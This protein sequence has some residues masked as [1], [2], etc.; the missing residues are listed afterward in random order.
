M[1]AT[2][3]LD[4]FRVSKTNSVMTNR[5]S[6]RMQSLC[7]D[8]RSGD[9][10]ITEVKDPLTMY[11]EFRGLVFADNKVALSAAFPPQQ[12]TELKNEALATTVVSGEFDTGKFLDSSPYIDPE[13]A[14]YYN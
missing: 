6:L 12:L 13:K 4:T 3:P 9:V 10:K 2:Q 14:T 7:T 8:T 1:A 11:N 5:M